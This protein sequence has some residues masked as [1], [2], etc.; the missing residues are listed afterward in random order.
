MENGTNKTRVVPIGPGEAHIQN[1]LLDKR[2]VICKNI[3][4]DMA[5]LRVK[6]TDLGMACLFHPGVVQEFAR[7]FKRAPLGWS[8][9]K[10]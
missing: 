3:S 8:T 2:C 9:E 1:K 6:D 10:A 7:Q 4:D 5:I